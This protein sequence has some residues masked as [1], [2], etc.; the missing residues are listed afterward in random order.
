[1]IRLSA[2]GNQ[3]AFY[4]CQF[5]GYQDTLFAKDGT[6]YYKNCY[7]EGPPPLSSLHERY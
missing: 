1:M 5:I 7:V 3:M 2:T 4:A 6:Q